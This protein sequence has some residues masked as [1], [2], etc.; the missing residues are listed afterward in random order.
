MES[1]CNVRINRFLG[2]LTLRAQLVVDQLLGA[3]GRLCVKMGFPHSMAVHATTILTRISCVLN[4][5]VLSYDLS[6][7]TDEHVLALER[8]LRADEGLAFTVNFLLEDFV[9]LVVKW[10]EPAISALLLTLIYNLLIHEDVDQN[11]AMAT[12]L[13]NILVTQRRGDKLGE[14]FGW[15]CET[16]ALETELLLVYIVLE[17]ALTED[18]EKS[19]S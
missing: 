5:T 4:Y 13:Y 19:P 17:A 10:E 15:Y 11:E 8:D 2:Y 1:P 6:D 14:Y 7:L 3:L 12:I 16:S 9:A 18:M